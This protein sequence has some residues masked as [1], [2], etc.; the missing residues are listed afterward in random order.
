MKLNPNTILLVDDEQDILEFLSYNLHNSGYRVL[1]ATNGLDAIEQAKEHLPGLIILDVMMPG[2]DGIETCQIIRETPDIKHSIIAMLSART[3]DY[4]Q[5]AGFDA[6]ADD[7]IKKPIRPSV[8]SSRIKALLRRLNKPAEHENQAIHLKDFTIDRERY[9][10][11]KDGKEIYLPKKE[12]EM[13]LMF[14]S[15]PNKVFSREEIMEKIWGSEVVVGDRTIDVH[16][17][18]I[19]EKVGLESIR[20][21]KGVGYSYSNSI[22]R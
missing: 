2:M 16:I 12:F 14:T 20:T 17:R 6:G 18:K 3:E 4:T 13:L 15:K 1:T 19:R 8:L 10:V 21:Y 5:L 7:Y 22:G 9:V 11:L